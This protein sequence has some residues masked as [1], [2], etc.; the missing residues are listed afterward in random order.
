MPVELIIGAT[1]CPAPPKA[2]SRTISAHTASCT[3]VLADDRGRCRTKSNAHHVQPA[4]NA[5]SNADGGNRGRTERRG[6]SSD[7]HVDHAEH[8]TRCCCGQ[9]DS[10]DR[11]D[12]RPIGR[13][14]SDQAASDAQPQP[15]AERQRPN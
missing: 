1:V 11:A 4:L 8:G 13:A 10:T 9:A 15:Q 6:V 5:M 3:K 2:P 7:E 12:R 14:E